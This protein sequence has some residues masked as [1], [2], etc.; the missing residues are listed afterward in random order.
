MDTIGDFLTRIRNAGAFKHDKVD[1][2]S[3]NLRSGIAEILQ[4]EGYIRNFKVAKDGKQGM[5]RVYLKY[6]NEGAHVIQKVERVSK[7][8]RRIYVNATSVPKVRS[9]YGLAIISTNKGILSGSE[10][11]KQN[12]GGEVLC[13]IW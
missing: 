7:P 4:K 1:L 5:M 12:V 3:S 6:D 2:P 11:Q 13:Q 8:S 9:G 10:A